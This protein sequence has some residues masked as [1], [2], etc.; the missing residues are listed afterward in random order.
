MRDA[1]FGAA[2][3][4]GVWTMAP[5]GMQ[6]WLDPRSSDYNSWRDRKR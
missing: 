2:R 4:F 5:R 3:G 6:P 1:A